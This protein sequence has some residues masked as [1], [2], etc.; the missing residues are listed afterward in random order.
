MLLKYLPLHV[1][2]VSSTNPGGH[3]QL[4]RWLY[5]WHSEGALHGFLSSQGFAH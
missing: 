4:G 1:S 2:E 3:A 5:T